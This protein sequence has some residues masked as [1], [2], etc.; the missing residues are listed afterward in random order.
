MLL[1]PVM[2]VAMK[3][4]VVKVVAMKAYVVMVVAMKA[5]VVKVVAYVV[6][7]QR[8][9]EETYGVN[10]TCIYCTMHS[11]LLITLDHCEFVCVHL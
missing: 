3:A 10:T 4:Y 5:Y 8:L 2:V 9:E 7:S 6:N 1:P 11:M